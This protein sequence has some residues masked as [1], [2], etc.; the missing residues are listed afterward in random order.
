MFIDILFAILAV[1]AIIKGFQKGLIVAVFSF[2]AFFIGLAAALKLSA[3]VAGYI[4][5]AVK[6]SDQWLPVISFAVVFIITVILVHLGAKAIEKSV[7]AVH[8]GWINRTGGILLYLL[9]YITIFSVLLFYAAQ[10]ELLKPET[11]QQSVCYEYVQPW[12]P[13]AINAMGKII[14]VFKDMFSQL[15]NFF[16]QLPGQMQKP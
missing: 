16:D 1:F 7:Q 9:I 15:E 3:V 11:I 13:K 2:V 8:L 4:G 5:K 12:G 6:I 14:P 10:L